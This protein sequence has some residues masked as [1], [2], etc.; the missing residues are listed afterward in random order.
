MGS[1]IGYKNVETLIRGMGLIPDHRLLL[2]SRISEK[3]HEE[4]SKLANAVGAN[5][6]FLNGVSDEE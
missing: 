3:R 4:L 2:T 6:E 5:V 1:F